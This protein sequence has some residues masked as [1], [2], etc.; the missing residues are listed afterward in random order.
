MFGSERRRSSKSRGEASET[1]RFGDG[2]V[3]RRRGSDRRGRNEVGR[4]REREG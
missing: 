1:E 4:A 2:E 3:W